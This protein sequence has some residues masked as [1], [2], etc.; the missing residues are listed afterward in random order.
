MFPAEQV[1]EIKSMLFVK[2]LL[3]VAVS[4]ISYLRALFPEDA[5]GDRCLEDVQLKIL[6]DDPAFPE[7]RTVIQWLRGAFEALEKKYLRAVVI[8]IYENPADPVTV[9]EEYTFKFSYGDGHGMDIYRN[10]QKILANNMEGGGDE[11]KMEKEIKKSTVRL[12]RTIVM[13]SQTLGS[14][15][16]NVNMAMKLLYF[17]EITP[18]DYN[19]NG[20]KECSQPEYQFEEKPNSWKVGN[21]ATNFHSM[22]VQI[23]TSRGGGDET[24][25]EEV[26]EEAPK[27]KKTNVSQM[28]DE[29]AVVPSHMEDMLNSKCGLQKSVDISSLYPSINPV[30]DKEMETDR[31]T[32]AS[33]D[34]DETQVTSNNGDS[35]TDITRCACGVHEDDGIMIL[36]ALCKTWQHA[37][38]YGIID[39]DAVPET[40]HCVDCA[41]RFTYAT[42]TDPKLIEAKTAEEVIQICLWRRALVAVTDV[43]MIAP[44]EL[45]KRLSVPINMAEALMKRLTIE[46][47]L[48]PVS[49]KGKRFAKRVDKVEILGRGYETYFNFSTTVSSILN[50]VTELTSNINISGAGD[51]HTLVPT[52]VA[53]GFDFES[54]QSQSQKSPSGSARKRRKTSIHSETITV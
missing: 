44:T 15:P 11:A 41:Q 40:H 36:C 26:Q 49:G 47:F 14:L 52:N 19:P 39:A 28:M 22:K 25:A 31:T 43:E 16:D 30:D 35:Q 48:V 24:G 33:D 29:E 7:A 38:C 12:L 50:D 51:K 9:V 23:K 3:A 5:F 13:L 34:E 53:D 18:D 20:F 10:G 27:R 2:K 45:S 54:Q 32:L 46:G 1:T 8:G 4:T 37:V 21:V 17:D 42:C 6:R